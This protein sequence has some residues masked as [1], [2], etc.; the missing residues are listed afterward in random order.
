MKNTKFN[1]SS[2][3]LFSE[4]KKEMLKIENK[5]EN[6]FSHRKSKKY[7]NKRDRLHE[8]WGAIWEADKLSFL[9]HPQSGLNPQIKNEAILL[10]HKIFNNSK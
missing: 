5:H 4:F 3:S 2:N 6:Y 8:H 1:N 10:F 7:E 9:F